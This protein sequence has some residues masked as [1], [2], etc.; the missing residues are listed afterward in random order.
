MPEQPFKGNDGVPERMAEAMTVTMT[1][2][3]SRHYHY[4]VV[5]YDRFDV[6]KHINH[7]IHNITATLSTRKGV[8]QPWRFF[9]ACFLVAFVSVVAHKLIPFKRQ[10]C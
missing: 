6:A 7:N 1:E 3:K 9:F 5:H 10:V 4:C 8:A 2:T